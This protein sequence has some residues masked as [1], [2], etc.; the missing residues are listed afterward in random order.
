MIKNH[1]KKIPLRVSA[2]FQRKLQIFLL[3]GR[4]L[5]LVCLGSSFRFHTCLL[6]R[7]VQV[8]HTCPDTQGALPF[9]LQEGYWTGTWLGRLSGMGTWGPSPPWPMPAA[10]AVAQRPMSAAHL[11]LFFSSH[12]MVIFISLYSWIHLWLYKWRWKLLGRVRLFATP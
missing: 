11:D 12:G 3:L 5:A 8:L 7:R 2:E 6:G 10:S 4:L 1:L 9:T